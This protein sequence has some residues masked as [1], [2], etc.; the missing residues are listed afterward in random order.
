ME[1]VCF[2]FRHKNRWREI[3]VVNDVMDQ[4][5][6]PSYDSPPLVETVLGVQFERLSGFK[7]GHL[8][9]YWKSLPRDQWPTVADAP[10]LEPQFERFEPSARWARGLHIQL[11]RD[12]ASR[13]Q[14][15]STDGDRMIQI[16][17]GRLHFNWLAVEGRAYPRYEKVRDGFDSA[18]NAL[19]AFLSQEEIGDFRPNQWEVTYVNHIAQG[20]VWNAP[21]DWSF[22]RPLGSAPT[23]LGVAIGESFA[24]EWHFVIPGHRGRLHVQWQHVL[25]TGTQQEQQE[26]DRLTFTARGPVQR[27]A[28]FVSSVMRG[29]DIG[30]ETIVRSFSNL[31]ADEANKHWGHKEC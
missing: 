15:T 2:D 1:L 10:S 4:G 30:R 27:E 17:N 29:L 16:Q 3:A 11:T 13:L 12:P 21:D 24:G 9:A 28:D 25:A 5:P 19:L 6:L 31:M 23:I 18:L 7:N 8:G 26:E 22:F 14:I 20:T